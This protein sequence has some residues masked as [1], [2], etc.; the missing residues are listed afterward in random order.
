MFWEGFRERESGFGA[1][2]VEAICALAGVHTWPLAG[3]AGRSRLRKKVGGVQ[4]LTTIS[5]RE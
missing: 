3:V 2:L 4:G 1:G 5:V